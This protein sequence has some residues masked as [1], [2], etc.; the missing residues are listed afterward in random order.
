MERFRCL[1]P[2]YCEGIFFDFFFGLVISCKQRSILFPVP[3]EP[4]QYNS[5]TNLGYTCIVAI[6]VGESKGIRSTLV[7]PEKRECN[8]LEPKQT[9]SIGTTGRCPTSSR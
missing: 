8:R 3:L 6:S 9:K 1:G 4:D 2:V 7:A 5:L